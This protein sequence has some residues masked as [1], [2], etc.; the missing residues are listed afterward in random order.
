MSAASVH[1]LVRHAVWAILV[2][3]S[4]AVIAAML[5]G[6][7]IA[8]LQAL[9]QIQESTLS[10]VPQIIAVLFALLLAADFMATQVMAVTQESYGQIE[11]IGR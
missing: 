9:T 7:A 11:S 8:L 5:V 1:D 6:T 3:S 4:P 10:F 2:S